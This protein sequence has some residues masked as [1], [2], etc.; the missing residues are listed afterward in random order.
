MKHIKYYESFQNIK[1]NE[2]VES[3]FNLNKKNGK[4]DTSFGKKNLEGLI[5]LIKS[6]KSVIEI[7]T[8]IF[9]SNEKN[10]KIDTSFG[11]K[12]LKGLENMIKDLK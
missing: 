7:A 6:D 8:G 1:I 3:I 12:T 10:G 11:K 9:N 2:L 4:I 5:N